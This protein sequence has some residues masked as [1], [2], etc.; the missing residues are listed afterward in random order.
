[1]RI[2]GT[3]TQWEDDR[4]FGFVTPAHGG[5]AIFVHISAF[6]KDARRPVVGEPLTFEI[7]VDARGK[8][9]AERVACA[10]RKS[11]GA[12]IERS[13][14]RQPK[15]SVGILGRVLP[16]VLL[17][18]AIWFGTHAYQARQHKPAIPLPATGQPSAALAGSVAYRCDGRTY[19]SQ[20]T[21]CEE[22]KWFLQHCPNTQ[23]DGNHDGVPCESQWCR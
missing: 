5:E 22:A 17:G 11:V 7:A 23:M 20:M 12:S 4:G 9:R 19:C 6:P 18:V 3:L 10:S 16:V 14:R 8:K 1:M 21:S 13:A 2:E 15:R